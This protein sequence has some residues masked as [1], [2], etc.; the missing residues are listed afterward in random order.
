M[1]MKN[2]MK[3]FFCAIACVCL[4]AI[5]GAANQNV[6][7]EDLIKIEQLQRRVDKLAAGSLGSNHYVVS[8]AR[9]WL[10]LALDEYHDKDR[11]GIVQSAS[12]EAAK[13]ID[14]LSAN[15]AFDGNATPH[16]YAS[17]KVREDLW[18]R[19]DAMKRDQDV[20]CASRKLAELEVQLVWAG[21]EKWESGW[22]HATPYARIAENLAYEA[23][24]SIEQCG[25]ARANKPATT[26]VVATPVAKTPEIQATSA[27][28]VSV[29]TNLTIVEKYTLSTDTNFAFGKQDI[30]NAPLA[31]KQ[32]LDHLIAQLKS[33]KS[34]A[35]INLVGHA[36]RLG[37]PTRN[38]A[39]ALQR[40]E[41]VKQYLVSQGLPSD[42]INTSGQGA[43]QSL[44]QCNDKVGKRP[45][46]ECL[47]ADRRVDI[48]V[49]GQR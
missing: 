2:P 33:W 44:T 19:V 12:N 29:V 47:Q 37:S 42:N 4:P 39:L 48:T 13:L 35:S 38:E 11:T 28:P 43:A 23:Q 26:V 21:H 46:I 30:I 18:T 27:P 5:A 3:K 6:T 36:D 15:P 34:V 7:P 10:D 9:A 40:A 14:G 25:K 1:M 45:L 49:T 24:T 41:Q 31:G 8:K 20:S 32:K 22:D 17:E 16:P